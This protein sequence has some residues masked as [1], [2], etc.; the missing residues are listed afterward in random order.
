M[1]E[2]LKAGD[3]IVGCVDYFYVSQKCPL[4]NKFTQYLLIGGATNLFIEIA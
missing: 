2:Q 4:S 3:K 1:R